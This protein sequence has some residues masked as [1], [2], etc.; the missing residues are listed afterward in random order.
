MTLNEAP[1]YL[2]KYGEPFE[3]R[4]SVLFFFVF[5]VQIAPHSNS[6]SININTARDCGLRAPSLGREMRWLEL[7]VLGE[8]TQG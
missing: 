8:G 7:E 5:L 1:F 6:I 3:G 4:R 2:P